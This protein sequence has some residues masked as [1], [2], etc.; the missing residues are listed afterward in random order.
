MDVSISK[1]VARAFEVIELFRE[2]RR[3]ASATEIRRLLD[4]P[5]SSMVAVLHNLADLGYLSYHPSTRLYFP[6]QKLSS[7]ASWLQPVLKGSGR[8]RE[9]TS[10]ISD[11]TG[12]T[13]VISC[14][15]AF[16]LNI[17]HAQKGSHPSAKEL[18]PGI[19][20]TLCRSIPGLAILSLLPDAEIIKLVEQ[21]NKWSGHVKADQARPVQQVLDQVNEVR[22]SGVSVGYNWSLA[23]TGAIAYP[24]ISPLDGMPLA[25][26]VTGDTQRIKA[27]A[28]RYRL[29]I[30]HYLQQRATGGTAPWARFVPPQEQEARFLR[31][32]PSTKPPR[33]AD[34]AL[35]L[36]LH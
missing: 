10:A 15:N 22:E 7:L 1:S 14:R 28:D 24:L 6:S 8:L 18:S 9:L 5:H 31:K 32:R 29:I 2:L 35:P 4:Y 26:S 25:L 33:R 20:I 16:F 17:V 30:E 27:N 11:V 3:P 36:G 13:T 12:Q 21:T 19:G 23:G 34:A